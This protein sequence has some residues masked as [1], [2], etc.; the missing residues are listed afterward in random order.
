MIARSVKLTDLTQRDSGLEQDAGVFSAEGRETYP[1]L[2]VGAY[3]RSRARGTAS[4][5]AK[6]LAATGLKSPCRKFA[7]ERASGFAKRQACDED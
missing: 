6:G 1:A 4:A 3:G 5:L 2:L 7:A